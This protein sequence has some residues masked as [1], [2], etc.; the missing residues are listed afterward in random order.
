MNNGW[1][2]VMKKV[3]VWAIILIMMIGLVGC[4]KKK[5]REALVNYVEYDTVEFDMIFNEMIESFNSGVGDDAINVAV[6][7]KE[8]RD[9]TLR[10]AEDA[11]IEAN[12]VAKGIEDEEV[13]KI[14]EMMITYLEEFVDF[15]N[16]TIEVLEEGNES[17]ITEVNARMAEL[18][19]M[20]SEYDEALVKLG[21]K[22]DVEIVITEN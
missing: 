1:K 7:L 3:L 5:Q 8:F 20:R 18:R 9:N 12:E 2:R 11:L 19:I 4:G 15:V 22:C 17:K 16:F 13:A 10:L 6:T 21:E 14:H